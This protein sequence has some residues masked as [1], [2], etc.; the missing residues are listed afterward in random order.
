MDSEQVENGA[1]DNQN[2]LFFGQEN[3]ISISEQPREKSSHF[4]KGCLL[5]LCLGHC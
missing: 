5:Q 4:E 2:L 1:A 3:V